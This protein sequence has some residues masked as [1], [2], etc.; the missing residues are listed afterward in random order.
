MGYAY[1]V[2]SNVS[3]VINLKAIHNYLTGL[4]NVNLVV[5]NVS[6]VINLKAIHN[7]ESAKLRYAAVVSNVSK[8]INL[9]AIHNIDIVN[10]EQMLLFPMC[11]R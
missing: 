11:Q 1:R 7:L 6:K 9:K 8:V 3:K 5:S 2:V 10:Y 4:V